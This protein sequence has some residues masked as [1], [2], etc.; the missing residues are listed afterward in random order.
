MAA[1]DIHSSSVRCSAVD[2]PAARRRRLSS[3]REKNQKRQQGVRQLSMMSFA[4]NT[5][6]YNRG[7]HCVFQFNEPLFLYIHGPIPLYKHTADEK[8][9]TAAVLTCFF[10]D[11]VQPVIREP[12]AEVCFHCIR[13]GLFLLFVSRTTKIRLH[14]PSDCAFHSF[15]RR[16]L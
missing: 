2:P 9:K 1:S 12:L 14:V 13:R 6:Q 15:W 4:L 11:C 7:K 5:L 10:F 16:S 3:K 8:G